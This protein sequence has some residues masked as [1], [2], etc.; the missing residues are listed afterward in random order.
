MADLVGYI[1]RGVESDENGSWIQKNEAVG[2]TEKVQ[3]CYG[4]GMA[5]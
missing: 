2:R 4:S 5:R 1:A 3:E